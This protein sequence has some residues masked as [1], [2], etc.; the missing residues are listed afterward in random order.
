MSA[1]QN[2]NKKLKQPAIFIPLV[3]SIVIVCF[4]TLI[5]KLTSTIY[6]Q[7]RDAILNQFITFTKQNGSLNPQEYWKFRE[8]Y[9]PGYFTFDR[10]GLVKD[11]TSAFINTTNIMLT[12]PTA[13]VFLQYTSPKL[14][15][16]DI[17]TSK[18]TLDD[19]VSINGSNKNI[20]YKDKTTQIF[21]QTP[22]TITI[23][24][25]KTANDMKKAN[26]FFDYQNE[27]KNI[28]VGKHWL[29]VTNIRTD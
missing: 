2:I 21:R 4:F 28:T 11:K 1:I 23:L 14:N 18:S 20:I 25:I 24:F 10:N 19:V 5:P 7:K 27:D 15:S 6:P 16:L 29:N 8:F 9:S 26:G 3:V 13:N 17:L 22:D 12:D